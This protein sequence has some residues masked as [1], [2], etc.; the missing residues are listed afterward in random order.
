M[1]NPLDRIELRVLGALIEKGVLFCA[2]PVALA[3][4]LLPLCQCQ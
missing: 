1:D 3:L 4:A 2:L